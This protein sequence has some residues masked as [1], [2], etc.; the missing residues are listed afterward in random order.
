MLAQCIHKQG[1]GYILRRNRL[2]K[3]RNNYINKAEVK[4]G[5][6]ICLCALNKVN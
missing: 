2:P 1:A 6:R 5:I 3:H 4:S